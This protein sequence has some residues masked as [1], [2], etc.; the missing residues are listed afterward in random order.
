MPMCPTISSH[1]A[2]REE[3]NYTY[4]RAISSSK[5]IEHFDH[6]YNWIVKYLAQHLG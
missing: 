3:I 6:I 1:M 5:Y 2:G 4:E